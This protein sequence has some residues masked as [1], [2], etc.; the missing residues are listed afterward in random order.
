MEIESKIAFSN[1]G[2]T[3]ASRN[4]KNQAVHPQL[5][6]LASRR[7]GLGV[8][9]EKREEA[10]VRLTTARKPTPFSSHE[11]SLGEIDECSD[12]L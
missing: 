8:S 9:H 5:S 7:S 2:Q 11:P 6:P 3:V 1:R 4:L 12:N 10:D